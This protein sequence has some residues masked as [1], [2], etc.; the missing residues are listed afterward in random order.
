MVCLLTP[1]VYKVLQ[2]YLLPSE[3]ETIRATCHKARHQCPP[4]D[5]SKRALSIDVGK[6]HMGV[7]IVEGTHCA[8]HGTA[9]R[10]ALRAWWLLNLKDG[11]VWHAVHELYKTS[12][13]ARWFA[14]FRPDGKHIGHVVLER[15]MAAK[16][17]ALTH[18]LQMLFLC[19][20]MSVS[21]VHHFS[22]VHKLRVYQGPL[23]DED[24]LY[25]ASLKRQYSRNKAMSVAHTRCLFR[26]DTGTPVTLCQGDAALHAL[27]QW[28][29]DSKA[30]DVCD[31]FLQGCAFFHQRQRE[32]VKA[33]DKAQREKRKPQKRRR[34][35]RIYPDDVWSPPL[36][37]NKRKRRKRSSSQ[38]V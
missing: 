30:D 12:M 14:W 16:M 5:I 22:T 34:L 3:E 15:Q 23:P 11:D 9:L 7:A 35:G 21:C 25:I 38:H 2:A 27:R 29:D 18:A 6:T 33:Y 26:G 28:Q 24:A 4:V 36:K 8:R 37:T 10:Y 19:Y 1:A 32:S 31:A 17:K 13:Q 20:H